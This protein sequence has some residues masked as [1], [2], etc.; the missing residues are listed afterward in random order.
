M[1]TQ[2][3]Q[4]QRG[5]CDTSAES[6]RLLDQKKKIKSRLRELDE[7]DEEDDEDDRALLLHNLRALSHRIKTLLG[8]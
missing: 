8:S 4:T 6:L 5:V 1:K 2:R 7:A 3:E